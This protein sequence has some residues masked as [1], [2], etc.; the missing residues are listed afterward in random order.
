M[1]CVKPQDMKALLSEA[2]KKISEKHLLISIAAGIKSDKLQDW[3]GNPAPIIRI[4]TNTAALIQEGCSV[5]SR[6]QFASNGNL[7]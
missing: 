6:G 4:M 3:I 2:S 7:L 1:L 5:F